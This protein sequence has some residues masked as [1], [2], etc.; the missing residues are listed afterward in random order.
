MSDEV[1]E[2]RIDTEQDVGQYYRNKLVG[3]ADGTP[4]QAV[5]LASFVHDQAIDRV[6]FLAMNIE[7]AEVAALR[8]MAP[9]ADC[10]RNVAIACHDFLADETGDE[11]MRTKADVRS[12]LREYGFEVRERA[13][14]PGWLR[15]FV[16]GVRR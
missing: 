1:G 7:G 16:Y 6:D 14:G 13:D 11:G 8:G 4:V 10:V 2:V 12:L 9:V 3:D 5:T 15:D